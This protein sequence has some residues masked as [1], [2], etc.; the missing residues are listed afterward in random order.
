[1]RKLATIQTI[2]A[3]SPIPEADKIEVATMNSVG[4]QVVVRKAEFQVGSKVVYVEID[5]M[6]PNVEWSKFLDKKNDGKPIRLRTVKLKKQISQGIIFPVSILPKDF[7]SFEDGVEISELLSIV[8]YDPPEISAQLAGICKGSF[9]SHTP[10]SDQQRLQ[11]NIGLLEEFKGKDVYIT[12]KMDGTSFTASYC[13]GEIDV[14]SRNMSLKETEENIYWKMAKKYDV[15]NK[16]IQN[17]KNISVQAELLGYGVQKNP[18][19]LKET[20]LWVFDVYDVD[21][22][23]Y[24]EYDAL[25]D[26]CSK[27]NLKMVPIIYNG[28]FKWN[29]IDELLDFAKG[30]YDNGHVREG[31]VIHP[32]KDFY[33]NTLYGRAS[34]KVINNDYLL[35]EKIT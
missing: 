24:F 17:A 7:N 30:T 29:S 15:V 2:K 33:S 20:E 3:I 26:F 34:F 27:W 1:M 11:S 19:G 4:W 18:M 5:S 9:P 22:G 23:R 10:K 14:C 31:I 25:V 13:N 6:L 21:K 28:I 12:V 35:A 16:L 8:K 32:L